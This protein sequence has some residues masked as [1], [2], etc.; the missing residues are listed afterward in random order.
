[1]QTEIDPYELARATAMI[2]G[3]DCRWSADA[4]LY[5]VLGVEC[6][7]YTALVNP[8]TGAPSRTWRL[9]G[10]LD[11]AVREKATGREGVV[12]HKTSGE[13]I[14]PGSEY[15]KRL[16]LDGQVSVYFEGARALGLDPQFCLYDVLLKPKLRPYKATALEDR[17][18]K[19]DGTLYAN[20]RE[21]D[22]TPEEY[23]DRL[24]EA[25]AEAPT[26]YFARG[27]VVRLESEMDDALFDVWQIGQ[28]MREAERAGRYP[29]NPDAC[30]RFGRTCSYF[31]V[32][33]GEASLTDPALFRRSELHP[34]LAS[35]NGSTAVLSSSRLKDA[36]ACQRLHRYRYI[37][38]IR[39]AVE[40]ESLRFGSLVHKALEAWWKAPPT[41]RLVSALNAITPQ[42]QST[43]S[44]ALASAQ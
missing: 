40:A 25:I 36:R 24:V 2:F 6:E 33:T 39:P 3:Y 38:C 8:S 17:K 13:D 23:R 9:G 34:E 21:R 5:E 1:M 35:V 27:E 44:L 11:A 30:V 10:K 19:K 15:W 22:E 42:P 14:T 29:R 37:D 26:S 12:E 31:G 7:F 20:Q 43:P 32:C 28:Q 4:D 41:A 16:R 18:F